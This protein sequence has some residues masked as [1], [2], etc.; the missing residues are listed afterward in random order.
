MNQS[1]HRVL[2]SAEPTASLPTVLAFVR[3]KEAGSFTAAARLLHVTPAAVSRSV[4]RLEAQL[5]TLLFRRSTRDLR[6]TPAGERYYARCVEAL[7]LLA[8]AERDARGAEGPPRGRV[9]ISLPTTYGLHRVVP[10]LAGFAEAHPEV[11]LELQVQNQVAD[12]VREGCDLAIR[13]GTID[14]ASLVARKLGEAPL[15][16]F[17]SPAYLDRHGRPRTVDALAQHVLLPFVLPRSGRVLPWLF[18]SPSLELVPSGPTPYRCMDDPQGLVALALAGLGL[19]QIYRFMVAHEVRA[20][21]L[22]EV[23]EKHGGRTRPFSL[24]YPKARIAPH[25]RVVIDWILAHAKL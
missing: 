8:L 21:R 18:A 1:F 10:A 12:F 14:D 9:R 7:G 23:L 6:P 19:C 24:V 16:V 3:T 22:V 11:V 20:G 17:A 15:G 4:A 13:L 5:E 2:E 25:V